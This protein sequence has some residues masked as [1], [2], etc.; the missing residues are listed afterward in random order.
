MQRFGLGSLRRCTN[1]LCAHTILYQPHPPKGIY[2]LRYVH[3][4]IMRAQQ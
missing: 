1:L 4:I 2:I 3:S